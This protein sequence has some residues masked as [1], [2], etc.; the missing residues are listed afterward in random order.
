MTTE[1]RQ[2]QGAPEAGG[3]PYIFSNFGEVGKVFSEVA[4]NPFAEFKMASLPENVAIASWQTFVFA[5]KYGLSELALEMVGVW[6]AS[7][8]ADGVNRWQYI[9]ATRPTTPEGMATVMR[10]QQGNIL[11]R[12]FHRKSQEPR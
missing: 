6:I 1:Q 10:V 5:C 9:M 2:F 8:S 11:Q 12:L 7:S 4:K 3:N